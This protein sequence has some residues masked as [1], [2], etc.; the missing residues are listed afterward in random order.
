MSWLNL[1]KNRQKEL[2]EQLSFRTG[3]LPQAIEK[4]AWVTLI[5][6]MLFSSEISEQLI[7]KG[8]TS[9]SK[10][11]E[12]IQRFSEDIDISINREFLGFTGDLTKGEIRKLRRKSHD[13][14]LNEMTKTIE[15]Q[16]NDYQI[17]NDKYEIIV[18]N[19][20]ISDQDPETI[21]INYQSVFN[22]I[23]YL[24]KRVLIEIGARSSTEPFERKQIKSLIDAHYTDTKITERE[25]EVR[26]I[27]PE[28]TFL[29]KLI[30]LHEEFTKPIEKI[31]HFRMSRHFYDIA[32]IIET[33]YGK[34]ALQDK[35]LFEQIIKHREKFTPIKTVDY[36]K[37]E[38]KKLKIF[39]D[40]KILELYEKD[41]NQMQ[42]SMIY[43]K[44]QE[45]NEIIELIKKITS[46]QHCV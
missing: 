40:D 33:E 20:K 43:G 35:K 39:P 3:I 6:R 13:F 2:F 41:Y 1:N 11:Y 25:F 18:E 8:G 27:R 14:T 12:L 42:E 16:L 19:T 22:E 37:L 21:Q 15:N 29:E 26:V 4:D 46:W 24:P 36:T 30:L 34:N 45:F 44:K 31:R 7:F 9:L 32:Q 38:L 10:V 28:K 17:S 5:L 23:G